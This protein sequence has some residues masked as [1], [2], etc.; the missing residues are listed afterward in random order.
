MTEEIREAIAEERF[1]DLKQSCED[2]EFRDK[3]LVEYNL[4]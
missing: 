2:K 1:D 4:K 3:L